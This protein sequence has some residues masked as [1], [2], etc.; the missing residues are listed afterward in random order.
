M[1]QQPYR[2]SDGGPFD[3]LVQE[4]IGWVYGVARRQLSDANLA[5][6]AT[7]AV[8]ITL[9]NKRKRLAKNARPVGGWLA[10]ATHYACENIKK[11]EWRRKIRERKVAAMRHEE[12]RG[13]ANAAAE[14]AKIEQLLAMDA[15]LQ[16][17]STGD[18][19][20][21]VAR[22]FQNQTARQVAEQFNISEAAAGKRITRAV[23]K[24]RHIMARKN[25]PMDSMALAGLLASGAGTAPG[26]LTETVLHGIGG[27][28][29]ISL[30]AAHAARSI[31]FH[32]AHIPAIAGAAVV[33]LAVS[34]AAV[35]PTALHDHAAEANGTT[36]KSPIPISY[37]TT[38]LT[39]PLTK[40][41]LVDYVAAFNQRFGKGVTP[42]NNAAVPLLIL[43]RPQSFQGGGYKMAAGKMVYVP[44]KNFGRELRS[45]LGISQR[46]LVG[47]RYIPLQVF[48]MKADYTAIPSMP[49]S[50][51]RGAITPGYMRNLARWPWSAKANPLVAA[52]LRAN[53]GALDIA[54]AAFARSRF[55][56]P[57]IRARAGQGMFAASVRT[58]GTL[59]D[60]KNLAPN[61]A[62]RAMLELHHG[63]IRRCE[64]DLIAA[65]RCLILATYEHFP[66]ILQRGLGHRS[67][68]S[69]VTAADEALANSGQLSSAQ[70]LA[71]LNMLKSLPRPVP[72]SEDEQT[73]QRWFTLDKI[74]RAAALGNHADLAWID[75]LLPHGGKPWH[76][77]Y[78]AEAATRLNSLADDIVQVL[79]VQGALNQQLSLTKLAARLR[80]GHELPMRTVTGIQSALSDLIAGESRGTSG[81]RIDKVCFALAAYLGDHGSFPT[82]LAQLEPKYLSTIPRDPFTGKPFRY[83]ASPTG[84]TIS[85]PGEFPPQFLATPQLPRGRPIIV[86]LSLPS[87][88]PSK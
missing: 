88:W 26:G 55:F 56:L 1:T 67:R 25:I 69:T 45:A 61:L 29:P 53:E 36:L 23:E 28:A 87:G 34:V 80:S 27:K 66:P 59:N 78:F 75:T 22:F 38:R 65:H 17:L 77:S 39:E 30:T 63:Q 2:E 16:R 85:S 62:R 52:W 54:A 12:T 14:E 15:A 24:L 40:N 10:R 74:Q 50:A 49:G 43:F 9:W 11:T 58:T 5:D 35:V 72:L 13:F 31:T 18:R 68:Q 60:I 84:C 44:D 7:Q 73:T 8:F 19:D 79:G 64:A 71:Y 32:T 33:A 48:L 6:D 81:T 41:G 3:R 82:R 37:A 83:I 86:H 51:G 4:H 76:Q 42:Q 20:V 21:L 70:A 46:D 57:I 47:P